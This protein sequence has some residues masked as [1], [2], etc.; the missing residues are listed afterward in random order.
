MRCLEYEI[1]INPFKESR[2]SLLGRCLRVSLPL[3]QRFISFQSL[4]IGESINCFFHWYQYFERLWLEYQIKINPFREMF[5][6]INTLLSKTHFS[7]WQIDESINYYSLHCYKY[8]EM[9]CL[10]YEIKTNLFRE[11]RHSLLGRCLRMSIPF[12]QRLIS[13]FDK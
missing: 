1:K 7:L 9:R 4:T 2:H 13:V 10:E 12:C 8:L 11:S 6:N 3:R 5:E